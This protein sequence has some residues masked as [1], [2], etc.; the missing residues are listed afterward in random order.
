MLLYLR[1]VLKN[2]NL[3]FDNSAAPLKCADVALDA[4]LPCQ[5]VSSEVP[6]AHDTRLPAWWA[7]WEECV[8]CQPLDISLDIA[9]R[10]DS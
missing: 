10:R 1:Y 5:L 7:Y 6:G 2:H 3:T 4:A 8:L 9:M